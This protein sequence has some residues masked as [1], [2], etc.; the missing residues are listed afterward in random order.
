M[1]SLNKEMEEKVVLTLDEEKLDEGFV[2]KDLDIVRKTIS[3]SQEIYSSNL[4]FVTCT[5]LSK[6]NLENLKSSYSDG[7]IDC[8]CEIFETLEEEAV[9]IT[10]SVV[11]DSKYLYL[12]KINLGHNK[13]QGLGQKAVSELESMYKGYKIVLYPFPIPWRFELGFDRKYMDESKKKIIDFYLSCG[14]EYNEELN[15]MT[16]NNL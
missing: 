13:G 14:Y 7:W 1:S 15:V 11:D 16:K 9:G 5:E 3:D 4:G 12:Q 10:E 2:I 8:F 6:E